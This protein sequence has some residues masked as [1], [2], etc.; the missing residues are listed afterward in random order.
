MH[1]RNVIRVLAVT[2]LAAEARIARGPEVSTIAG[3]GQSATLALRIDAAIARGTKAIISFGIAG[4]LD[5]ALRPGTLIVARAVFDDGARWPVHEA[6]SDA[7]ERRLGSVLRADIAGVDDV[8]TSVDDKSVLFRSSGAVAVDM[9][10]HIAARLAAAHGI[11]FAALRVVSDPARR[12]LPPAAAIGL[13]GDGS[14][15]VIRVLGSLLREPGQFPLL[16]RAA[17]DA[18]AAMRGLRRGRRLLGDSLGFGDLGK[19]HLD[20]L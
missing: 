4:A 7:L 18:H 19:L 6:W 10:S 8:V 12:P 16:A 15:D 5:P 11:P 2:G 13:R 3:G 1:R 9:E 17:L 20:V 14:V